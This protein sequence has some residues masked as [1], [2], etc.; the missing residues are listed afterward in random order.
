MSP[1]TFA[2]VKGLTI[3][4]GWNK[5]L[6]ELL[7]G[8]HGCTHH[9]EM[10]GAMATVAFQ[11]MWGRIHRDKAV[12][13]SGSSHRPRVIDSCYAFDA[14]GEVVKKNWPQFYTGPVEKKA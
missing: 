10:L 7:G 3:G 2:V 1:R 11:T 6:K 9:V 4:S 8:T 12:P 5:K 13:E 14:A